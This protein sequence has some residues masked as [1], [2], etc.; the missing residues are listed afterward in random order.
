LIRST[1]AAD[2]DQPAVALSMVMALPAA[3]SNFRRST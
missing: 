2:E 1:R 3:V